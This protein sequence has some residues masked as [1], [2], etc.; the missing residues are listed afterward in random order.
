MDVSND[1]I[2]S[3]FMNLLDNAVEACGRLPEDGE[4]WIYLELKLENGEFVIRCANSA[5][6]GQI[7]ETG[8]SKADQA[9]PRLWTGRDG[10]G[11]RAERRNFKNREG[12]GQ[13]PG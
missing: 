6:P 5:V 7:E 10:G 1:D 4:R 9:V 13:L 11:G 3:L 8:T 2:T 12:R